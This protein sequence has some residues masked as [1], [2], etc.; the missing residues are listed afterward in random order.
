MPRVPKIEANTR[1]QGIGANTS[2]NSLR[3]TQINLPSVPVLDT[4]R[5]AARL[6]QA[7]TNVGLEGM[8]LADES[9]K[10]ADRVRLMEAQNHID[11]WKNDNIYA[12][13]G[14][15]TSRGRDAFDVPDT[16]TQRYDADMQKFEE[17]LAN[18]EQRLAF[19][20]MRNKSRIGIEREL[21]VHSRRQMDSYA[22]SVF[23]ANQEMS[24]D[25]AMKNPFNTPI[26]ENSIG[27][28]KNAITEYGAIKGMPEDSVRLMHEKVESNIR[29]G[30]LSNMADASPAAGMQYYNQFQ[31]VFTAEDM[32]KAQK[33]LRPMQRK[34][35]AQS[36]AG[37]AMLKA[38]PA[39][40]RDEMIDFVMYDIEG[41]EAIVPDGGGVSKF[42]INS[43]ANPDVDVENL[44][45]DQAKQ[46]Y[47]DRYWD[48]L[49]IDSMPQEMKLVAFDA[50]VNHGEAKARKL[51]DAAD[52]DPRRLV[53]LRQEEYNRLARQNPDKYGDF[54][55]GW[56]NRLSKVE[57]QISIL[58]GKLPTTAELYAEIESR[59]DDPEVREEARN[60]VDRNIK[61]IS[62]S[63]KQEEQAASDEAWRYI[64]SG[65]EVPA[66]VE[67]NMNPKDAEDMRNKRTPDLALYENLRR[68]ITTGRDVNIDEYRW[69]LGN[70]YDD[71]A[72]LISKPENISNART[73]DKVIKNASGMLLGHSTAKSTE[74]FQKVER[75]R[76]AVDMEIQA[77][78]SSTG[79]KA[80]A[81]D[82]QKI[83]DR[84]LLEVETGF[85]SDKRIF[86][87]NPGEAFDIP[88]LPDLDRLNVMRPSGAA[89]DKD[90]LI[91]E[92][93]GIL[94]DANMEI[95]S[96]NI[97]NLYE[98]MIAQEQIVVKDK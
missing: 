82:V 31:G 21:H 29:L 63:R 25:R 20:E 79:R 1:I 62:D 26:V 51:I 75:F 60:M 17:S 98:E 28:M 72:E 50:A 46:I 77:L 43:V 78:Q 7:I 11:Q 23:K 92:L 61:I 16:Y 35:A 13:G 64:Q 15:L 48:K 80:N 89:V 37:E 94:S 54:L 66:S 33:L 59:T 81:D 87:L 38:L 18:D 4:G 41:G 9:R 56:S 2:G 22:D 45:P 24:A 85:F 14:A 93:V 58:N 19:Q 91:T 83:T 5:G 30:V 39:V 84:L 57:S 71:L 70:K 47:I 76:R 97:E 10:R 42:G 6:G 40:N 95:N 3:A 68:Q 52:G 53:E 67:A 49:N 32:I 8:K 73:V 88:G 96:D 55:D 65:R 12:D 27:S 34:V 44:T 36:V 69:R 90:T 74:E 86:E